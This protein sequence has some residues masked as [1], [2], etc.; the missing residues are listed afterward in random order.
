MKTEDIINFWERDASGKIIP[1]EKDLIIENLMFSSEIE[2]YENLLLQP[3]LDE[4]NKDVYKKVIQEL[5]EKAKEYETKVKVK[6]IPLLNFELRLINKGLSCSGVLVDDLNAEICATHCLE[7]KYSYEQWRDSR[8]AILK[9]RIAKLIFNNSFPELNEKDIE[10]KKKIL[11][12]L[13]QL[14]K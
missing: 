3:E 6:F 1:L 14:S 9:S 4:V 10:A 7:P 13:Q 5:K 2:K 12:T 8:D 11:E